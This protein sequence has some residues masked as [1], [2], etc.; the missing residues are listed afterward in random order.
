MKD[1]PIFVAISDVGLRTECQHIVAATG[2][3]IIESTDPRHM[4]L[5]APRVAAMLV[6]ATTA[7]HAA[8][9]HPATR[10]F[11][12]SSTGIEPDWQLALN[13]HAEAAYSLPSQANELLLQLATEPHTQHSGLLL[14]VY[15]A[16]GGVGTST[17]AACL[18]QGSIGQWGLPVVL[19]DTDPHGGGLDLL[20]GIEEKPGLRWNDLGDAAADIAGAELVSALPCTAQGVRVLSWHREDGNHRPHADSHAVI[21]NLRQHAVVIVDTPRVNT[22]E[23]LK[24]SDVVV[25]IIPA[26][27]RAVAALL[28]ML[29]QLRSHHIHLCAIVRQR[30]W[31][32]LSPT[33]LADITGLSMTAVISNSHRLAKAIEIAGIP[34]YLPRSMRTAIAQV[35]QALQE[36]QAT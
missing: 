15:G 21:E 12:M 27:I 25:L 17:F 3:Q 13:C 26:E 32:G 24:A 18:A 34:R 14:S 4:T 33:E 16:A 5:Q 30:H 22:M 23:L 1:A 31:S 36:V 35:L 29:S 2:K 6:D 28:P 7:A 8:T 10:I 9:L 20:C 19:V 11:F